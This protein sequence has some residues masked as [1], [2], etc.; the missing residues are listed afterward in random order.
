MSAGLH[1]REL[2]GRFYALQQSLPVLQMNH[3]V[4]N[5]RVESPPQTLFAQVIT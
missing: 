5:S 4:L 1:Y 3:E 2:V